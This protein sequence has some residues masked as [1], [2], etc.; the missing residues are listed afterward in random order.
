MKVNASSLI[1][2]LQFYNGIN[3]CGHLACM[4]LKNFT[5]YVRIFIF[6]RVS[7]MRVLLYKKMKNC[8]FHKKKLFWC[9]FFRSLMRNS[10]VPSGIVILNWWDFHALSSILALNLSF[11]QIF[12][13]VITF[14]FKVEFSSYH[15]FLIKNN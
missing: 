15:D 10:Y 12:L 14:Q 7:F 8:M 5:A 13:T 1:P 2:T 11:L 9:T 6:D 4:K 3:K